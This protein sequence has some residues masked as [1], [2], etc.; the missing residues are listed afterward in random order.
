MAEINVSIPEKLAFLFEP[1]RYKIAYGG[2]GSAKSWSF[3]RALIIKALESKHRILCCREVQ[4][5]IKDSVHRLISDQIQMMGLGAYFEITEREI[6][7]PITGSQFLFAGLAS[8][9]V[10]SI[11]SFEGVSIAWVEEAQVVSERS[12]EILI[13]TI[14]ADDSEIWISLNPELETDPTYKRFVKN[15]HLLADAKCVK[16]NYDD[17][18]HFPDV[19]KEEMET[20]RKADIEAYLHIWEGQCKRHGNAI[21]F[22]D[23]YTSYDFT[24]QK[25]WNGPYFGSDFGFAN[26]PT[27]LIKSWVYERKLYIEYEVF[28]S[29]LEIDMTPAA[30][31]EITNSRSYIIRADCA[32]PETISYMKRNGFKKMIACKKWKGSVEDGVDFLRS[33]D[34][35][36]IHPRCKHILDEFSLYSYKVDS[37]TKEVLPEIVDKHNHGIDAV[38][39]SLEPLILGYK[40][41]IPERPDSPIKDNYG[42]PITI[43]KIFNPNA[44]I[45]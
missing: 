31:D 1:Y 41:P 3:T 32:R 8:N 20:L 9:T 23:K 22:K 40:Q 33:F 30:F 18:P 26:D 45:S 12:W 21:V 29:Q 5:S 27:T 37:L 17:N 4:K 13:P 24:P 10:E 6:R 44:W 36:V 14:R 42:N 15:A 16:I 38:R 43:H 11:K 7:C 39:Y 34:E 28:A 2:R 35:I 25:E 19:L